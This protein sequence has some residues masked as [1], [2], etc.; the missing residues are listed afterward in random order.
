MDKLTVVCPMVALSTAYWT[1]LYNGPRTSIS[2]HSVIS[3]EFDIYTRTLLNYGQ[4]N[5]CLTVA[6]LSSGHLSTM[7][8]KHMKCRFE[9]TYF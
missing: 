3:T 8:I 9:L 5:S 6:A 1:P 4:I 7:D 2:Y